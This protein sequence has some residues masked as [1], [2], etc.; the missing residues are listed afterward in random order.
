MKK[1][2]RM[3][4]YMLS[5][6]PNTS[7][8][9]KADIFIKYATFLQLELKLGMYIPCNYGNIPL[10]KPIFLDTMES[11]ENRS[12]DSQMSY[13]EQACKNVIFDGFEINR[14][15]DGY[16]YISGHNLH[17]KYSINA[18]M[19]IEY[20]IV[21]DLCGMV[22]LTDNV[23]FEPS[24]NNEMVSEVNHLDFIYNRMIHY[25]GE[26]ENYDYMIAFEKIISTKRK[27]AGMVPITVYEYEIFFDNEEDGFMSNGGWFPI[28]SD[29]IN[30]EKID[31]YISRGTLRKLHSNGN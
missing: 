16:I 3:C 25:H 10:E 28:E 26:N 29:R 8:L 27:D 7:N 30:P 13:Y 15:T 24:I 6:N 20:S 1:L 17:M 18:Q 22:Y 14:T 12:F 9:N 19:F 2:Q 4:E 21:E 31:Y 5:I 23:S 11:V